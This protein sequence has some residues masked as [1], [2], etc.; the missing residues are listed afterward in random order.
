[1][2]LAPDET[3]GPYRLVARAGVGGMAEVWRAFQPR[4][5]RDVAIKILPRHF[6]AQAGFLERFEQEALSISRLQHPH[7]LPVFDY[8]EQDG[9]TY[10][11]MPFVS[12]GTLLQKLG[13]A[14][15]LEEALG[16]LEPLATALDYAHARGIIHRDVKPSNVLLGDDNW[17][18]LGDFGVLK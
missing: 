3:L 12:G 18:L 16:A 17:I 4:L 9:F 10:M 6:A 2:E 14:W 5:Q 8:G 15:P 7:I 1:M 13:R 11:V